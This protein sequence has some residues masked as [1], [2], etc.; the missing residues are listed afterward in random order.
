MTTLKEV[1]EHAGVSFKTVSR[2]ANDSPN[3]AEKTRQKVLQSMRKLGYRPNLAARTMRTGKSQLIGFITDEIASE[4]HAGNVIRGAQRAAWEHEKLLF[5]VN[6]EQDPKIEKRA[7][8]IMLE[9]RVDAIIYGTWYHREVKPPPE[10]YEVPCVLVDCFVSDNSITSV[11]PDEIRGGRE[12]T[13]ALLES[14][15]QRVAFLNNIDPVPATFGRLEGYKQA[16]ENFNIPFDDNLYL[17]SKGDSR[18]A[19]EGGL[20]LLEQANP[21]TAIF[22]FNDQMAMGVYDAVK[23]NG[24]TY[25]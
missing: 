13:T 20:Q 5:V 3:V 6:T 11:V 4:A 1:A 8:Q 2:V 22:C 24:L 21:P 19:Y 16:L 15:H 23:N 18:R 10:I 9:R 7:F 17:Q 14:G 25:P 12:A